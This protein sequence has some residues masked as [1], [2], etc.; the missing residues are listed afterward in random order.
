MKWTIQEL[1]RNAKSNNEISADVDLSSYVNGI[2]VLD[3]SVVHVEGEYE[4]YDNNEF[5]FYL[6]IDCTL[7]LPCAIT[8]KPV[9][10]P[11][12]VET[13]ESFT[14]FKDDDPHHI[15]GITIDLLP[16]IWSNI[17]LEMPMRVVSEGAYDEVSFENDD[18]ELEKDNVFASLKTNK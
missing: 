1:I 17:L 3:I 2:E 8:L 11:M 18:I 14:T 13:E 4:V 16:I 12:H 15:E 5:V 6:D 10:Y 7:T 9:K